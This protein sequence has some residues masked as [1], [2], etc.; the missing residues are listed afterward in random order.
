MSVLAE[1]CHDA[2]RNIASP[3]RIVFRDQAIGARKIETARHIGS[4][5]SR[6]PFLRRQARLAAN[7]LKSRSRRRLDGEIF[8]QG[9]QAGLGPRCARTHILRQLLKVQVKFDPDSVCS[10]TDDLIRKKFPHPGILN[11]FNNTVTGRSKFDADPRPAG[12][13]SPGL[14]ERQ[15]IRS[16]LPLFINGDFSLVTAPGKARRPYAQHSANSSKTP[17]LKVDGA[18]IGGIRA[19]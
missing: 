14:T 9:R 12:A 6:K 11:Q 4:L 16:K 13:A 7:N 19:L 10:C 8:R 1:F 2:E 3:G 18:A 5:R 17:W 15:V